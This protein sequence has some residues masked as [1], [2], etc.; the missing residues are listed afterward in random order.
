MEIHFRK[1][2]HR[3]PAGFLGSVT[4]HF[5]EFQQGFHSHI[6]DLTHCSFR[7]LVTTAFQP[8]I[9]A[10]DPRF[11]F[12]PISDQALFLNHGQSK[13]PFLLPAF[14]PE[15]IP[16]HPLKSHLREI[17]YNHQ[18]FHRKGFTKK[19]AFPFPKEMLVKGGKRERHLSCGWDRPFRA[20]QRQRHGFPCF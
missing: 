8:P 12:H 4:Q 13:H 15:R 10:S 19:P 14:Q 2:Q 9:T 18:L 6:S 17:E 11:I 5:H 3:P 16:L 20:D 1:N 7:A